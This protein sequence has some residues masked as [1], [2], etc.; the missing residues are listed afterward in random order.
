MHIFSSVCFPWHAISKQQFVSLKCCYSPSY[1]LTKVKNT[2]CFTDAFLLE[3]PQICNY[4][5]CFLAISCIISSLT[6]SV[7]LAVLPDLHLWHLSHCW[8]LS[9]QACSTSLLLSI[10]IFSLSKIS[11]SCTFSTATTLIFTSTVLCCQCLFFFF[12]GGASSLFFFLS[13]LK[14]L[15]FSQVF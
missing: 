8:H 4:L 9:P 1:I 5:Y 15:I 6:S 10:V 11:Q 13:T 7:S 12:W 2:E 14:N 3:K